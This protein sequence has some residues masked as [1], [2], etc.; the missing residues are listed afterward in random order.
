MAAQR[1]GGRAGGSRLPRHQLY[2]VQAFDVMMPTTTP[3]ASSKR[4]PSST[5]TARPRMVSARASYALRCGVAIG[6]GSLLSLVPTYAPATADFLPTLSTLLSPVFAGICAAPPHLGASLKNTVQ[7]VIGLLYGA[8]LATAA[9]AIFG[10]GTDKQSLAALVPTSLLVL[11]APGVPALSAKVAQIIVGASLFS[12]KR[13]PGFDLFFPLQLIVASGVGVACALLVCVLPWPHSRACAAAEAAAASGERAVASLGALAA[14]ALGDESAAPAVAAALRSRLEAQ[15]AT[16]VAAVAAL[17]AT[18]EGV[19]AEASVGFARPYRLAARAAALDAALL[20]AD[21]MLLALD[22]S[23]AAHAAHAKHTVR[24][25]LRRVAASSSALAPAEDA[26]IDADAVAAQLDEAFQHENRQIEVLRAAPAAALGDTAAAALLTSAKGARARDAES[27]ERGTSLLPADAAASAVAALAAFDAALL[28]GRAAVF[29]QDSDA[30]HKYTDPPVDNYAFFY[31]T[32]QWALQCIAACAQD[33]PLPSPPP[34]SSIAARLAAACSLPS[35]A[36]VVYG[37]KL[38]AASV[39]AALLGIA[40]CGN[41]IWAVIAVNIVGAR[42]GVFLGAPFRTAWARV[43]GTAAAAA[44]SAVLLATSEAVTGEPPSPASPPLLAPMALWAVVCSAIRFSPANAYAGMV[45]SYTPYVIT[46]DPEVFEGRAFAYRRLEQQVLGLSAFAFIELGIAPEHASLR[47]PA[48]AARALRA[49]AAA[50]AAVWAP[51]LTRCSAC[52][53]AAS[54]EA[55]SSLAALRA[56]VAE[57]K[58]LLAEAA[59]EPMLWPRRGAP[60]AAPLDA[61]RRAVEAQH[62]PLTTLLALMCAAAPVATDAHALRGVAAPVESALRLLLHRLATLLR[63]LADEVAAGA[64]TRAIIHATALLDEALEDVEAR[65][66]AAVVR[67]RISRR[68]AV[69]GDAALAIPPSDAMLSLHALMLCTRLLVGA[70]HDVGRAVRALLPPRRSGDAEDDEDDFGD[71]AA[72]NALEERSN[73]PLLHT[74][75][76]SNDDDD[77][78]V[79]G[80]AWGA[81]CVCGARLPDDGLA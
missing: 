35:R 51:A 55:T 11:L 23:R 45:S 8:A 54:A 42:D 80:T 38:T 70:A 28:R 44:F 31:F 73:A 21:G 3:G 81:R 57:Q 37:V 29:Y 52:A 62:A 14:R 5:C 4:A 60:P 41:G 15:H 13:L 74:N 40:S 1:P 6:C 17:K 56:G 76:A 67:L 72:E 33:P 58:A 61:W 25:R 12:A 26:E 68:D 27:A 71:L 10:F 63:A 43:V 69:A 77:A 20:S 2:L 75:E 50:A 18:R 39:C 19:D 66:G 24:R 9:L 79:D 59:G 47:L 53:A 46:F 16:A 7:T 48:A 22:A 78:D 65:H 36:R 34:Q 64:R 32:R 49:A 30:L